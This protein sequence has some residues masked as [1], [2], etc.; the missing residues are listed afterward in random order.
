MTPEEKAKELI[1]KF[2]DQIEDF[3]VQCGMYCQGG[4]INIIGLSKQCAGIAVEEIIK[5]PPMYTGSLNPV[6]EYWQQVK[7]QIEK[8]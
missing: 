7:Q 6:W 3:P 2:Y 5:V 8:L 1:A 4:S